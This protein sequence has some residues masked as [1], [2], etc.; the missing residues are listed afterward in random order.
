MTHFHM[1]DMIREPP[2]SGFFLYRYHHGH[3][4]SPL[5]NVA[6]SMGVLFYHIQ[7]CIENKQYQSQKDL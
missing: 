7:L 4:F 6:Q 2:D 3:H 1:L 5:E